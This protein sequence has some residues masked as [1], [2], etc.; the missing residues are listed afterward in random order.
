MLGAKGAEAENQTDTEV[1]RAVLRKGGGK[2]I[3]RQCMTMEKVPLLTARHL[4]VSAQWKRGCG[5]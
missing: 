3:P 1:N 4:E 2:G 5:L